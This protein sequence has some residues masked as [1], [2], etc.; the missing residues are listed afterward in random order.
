[1]ALQDFPNKQGI[2]ITPLISQSG[3]DNIVLT[4]TTM[5]AVGESTSYLGHLLW[6]DG[7]SHTVSSAGGKIYLLFTVVSAWANVGTNLRVGIQDLTSGLEDGTFDVFDDLVPGT[8]TLTADVI[9]TVTMSSGTKTIAHSDLIAVVIEMTARGGTD[10]VSPA[11]VTA[12][13]GM[14]YCAVDS[15]VGVTRSASMPFCLI[16]A[17]DGAVGWFHQACVPYTSTNTSFNSGSTPDEYALIFSLPFKATTNMLFANIGD[18]DAGENGEVILY[19]DPTGTP[20]AE[21]TYTHTGDNYGTIGNASG[22]LNAP[23][24]EFTLQPNTTYAV[25]YRPTTVANRILKRITSIPSANSRKTTPF[26]TT[27]LGGTRTDN[28]GAFATSTTDFPVL[29]LYVNKLSDDVGSGS[30]GTRAYSG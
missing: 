16:E 17:D 21:R 24:T 8:D 4:Q 10:A 1:M 30:G 13:A 22:M 11:R 23:I 18:V 20:V 14:P 3:M 2:L 28:T 26:G 7:A 5:D 25:A 6:E 19:S 12:N 15:G 9:K 27:L 29:G